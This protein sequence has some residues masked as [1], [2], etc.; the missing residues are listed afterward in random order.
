MGGAEEYWTEYGAATP[1]RETVRC[2]TVARERSAP[3]CLCP[4]W[5]LRARTGYDQ[6]WFGV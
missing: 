1:R 5:A 3:G 2:G 4:K 6:P